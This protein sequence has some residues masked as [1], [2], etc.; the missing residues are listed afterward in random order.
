MHFLI[1]A[2]RKWSAEY[3]RP[4][5]D[6]PW[7]WAPLEEIDV[8]NDLVLMVDQNANVS[9][10]IFIEAATKS[11]WLFSI[12]ADREIQWSWGK[13]ILSSYTNR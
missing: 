4:N 13:D 11:R 12:D 8:F 6:Q 2:D 1:W 5:P 10:A 3:K 9:I 7:D